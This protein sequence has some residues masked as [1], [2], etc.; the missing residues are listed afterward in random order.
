MAFCLSHD[1]G[2]QV[3]QSWGPLS[4]LRVAEGM[5]S[6]ALVG[7]A[8]GVTSCAMDGTTAKT[9]GMKR[10]AADVLNMSFL[11]EM[12]CVCHGLNDVMVKGTVQ[13]IL[14]RRV[15]L[16]VPESL[17][18]PMVL[19]FLLSTPVMADQTVQTVL[20]SRLVHVMRTSSG[21]R[22]APV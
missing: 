13:T 15:V 1:F 14:M 7:T 9:G 5:S 22:V 6:F 16:A 20:M 19:A 4:F 2:L 8:S 3:F 21:A 12:G 18:A 10:I 11:V 17:P